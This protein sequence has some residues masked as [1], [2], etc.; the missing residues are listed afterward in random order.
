MK[1]GDRKQVRVGERGP[2]EDSQEQKP[3]VRRVED[4]DEKENV[5]AKGH[6]LQ[7]PHLKASS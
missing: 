6:P 4:G 1:N 7:G 5:P 3:W 2:R